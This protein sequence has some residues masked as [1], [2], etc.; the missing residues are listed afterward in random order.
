MK[1]ITILFILLLALPAHAGEDGGAPGSFLRFGTSARSLALGNAMTGVA[2]DASAAYWNP[3]GYARLRTVELTGMGATLFE[4]TQYSFFTLGLPTESWG[5]FALSGAYM[6][7]GSFERATLFEDLDETFSESSGYFGL[8][9]ARAHGR[10]AW[11]ATMKSVT[12]NVADASGGSFGA[13]LGLY[14][15]PHRTISVGLAMQ[16]ALAPEIKLNETPDTFARTMRVGTAL[17]FFRNRFT[18][19]TDVVKTELMDVDLRS[20]AEFWVDR[21][22]AVRLG[23]D[24]VREQ[25]STGAAFRWENWQVDYAYLMHELG[26]TNVLSATVRFGVP[27]GVKLNQDRELFSPSGSD[28]NVNFGI[29]T[30]VQGRVEDWRLEIR[31]SEGK[32][33]RVVEGNGSPPEEFSWAGED[34]QGRLVPDG[35]YKVRVSILDDMG[36]IWDYDA[37]VKVLGFKER[38]REPI[39]IELSGTSEEDQEGER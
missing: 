24:T 32:L 36:E 27:Y 23:F 28:R 17:H 5:S 10:W 38:T 19:T 35:N 18:I 2:D 37:S 21:A 29:N 11:G 31:D 22:F 34:D 1:R 4:D 25:L 7:S 6:S 26:S 14:Y 13:D 20:G 15:R 12:Q 3:A 8:S 9:Y 33:V 16:N 39:R 30:A